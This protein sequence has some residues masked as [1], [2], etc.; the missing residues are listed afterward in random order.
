MR[1]SVELLLNTGKPTIPNTLMLYILK[2]IDSLK[3][4][5]L[6]TELISI[7]QFFHWVEIIKLKFKVNQPFHKKL[8]IYFFDLAYKYAGVLIIILEIPESALLKLFH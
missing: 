5:P 2:S 1:N 4:T 7:Y 8:F 6:I 3:K